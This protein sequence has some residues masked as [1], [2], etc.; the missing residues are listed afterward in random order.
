MTDSTDLAEAAA[1]LAM[2][3]RLLQTT[4]GEMLDWAVGIAT[5]GPMGDGRYP[6][7]AADG[8]TLLVPC[9]ARISGTSPYRIFTPMLVTIWCGQSNA[10]GTQTDRTNDYVVDRATLVF[11]RNYGLIPYQPGVFT[12][13]D[14]A[15]ESDHWAAEMRYAQRLRVAMP[16]MPHLIVKWAASGTQL[17]QSPGGTG[18]T[19]DWNIHSPGEFFDQGRAYLRD[20]LTAI[21]A[22]GYDPVIRLVHWQQGEADAND[23]AMAQA[24]QA[25]LTDLITGW[26]AIDGW[27]VPKG[28]TVYIGR[29]REGY[30]QG[31][32]AGGIV[33]L[34]QQA[35]V[36]ARPGGPA[37]LIDNDDFAV[38][39]DYTHYT[40][41][42]L[43]LNG[44]RV[45]DAD[46]L[47]AA[48]SPAP[49][50]VTGFKA[51]ATSTT[52]LQLRFN[53]AANAPA[54]QYLLN[55]AGAWL[56]LAT[57]KVIDGLQAGTTYQVRVRGIN[58]YGPGPATDS[59]EI[60]TQ[61]A[62][63]QSI[64]ANGGF[65]DGEHWEALFGGRSVSGGKLHYVD[66]PP[67]NG[68]YQTLPLV[69]YVTYEV[70]FTISNWV[71]GS[72][73]FIFQG[74]SGAAK[75]SAFFGSNGT[76]SFRMMADPGHT[77]FNIVAIGTYGNGPTTLDIDDISIV[78]VT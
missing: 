67:Y 51:T 45:A 52:T 19:Y 62:G 36:A 44:D 38:E 28:A 75:T 30:S 68:S 6:F 4:R 76:H 55:N 10:V 1:A 40:K 23:T 69:Q 74:G 16:K 78:P 21:R 24:Y 37:V 43:I 17:A 56:P 2:A 27:Q 71:A 42:S 26:R 39:A 59:F 77:T 46:G 47:G 41:A 34:A 11:R 29:L 8:T 72:L 31:T 57:S 70:T 3:T 15:L 54:Y 9:P 53:D 50:V 32:V 58:A 73:M 14:N 7:T 33:R 64:L 20:A 5:G 48:A 18:D 61:T 22:A 49:G 25:N 60:A 35:V 66:V 65:V 63:P 12:G 13:Y